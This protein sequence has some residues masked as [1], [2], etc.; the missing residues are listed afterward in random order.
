MF[1]LQNE[2]YSSKPAPSLPSVAKLKPLLDDDEPNRC[3]TLTRKS[4]PRFDPVACGW[5]RFLSAI[6]QA[7]YDPSQLCKTGSIS[8]TNRTR[9]SGRCL[10][11]SIAKV[12]SRGRPE[13]CSEFSS[14]VQTIS[15]AGLLSLELEREDPWIRIVSYRLKRPLR[16][17]SG[18]SEAVRGGWV[19]P[20]EPARL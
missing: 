20:S 18:D 3:P 2:A 17:A 6:H 9:L 19:R 10:A 12:N 13:R 1:R 7:G 14:S 8:R 15:P 5:Y 4:T 16:P 11:T